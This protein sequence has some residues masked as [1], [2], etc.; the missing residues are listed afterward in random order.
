MEHRRSPDVQYF[1]ISYS[2]GMQGLDVSTEGQIL[3][4]SCQQTSSE[5]IMAG[6]VL[7]RDKH[8]LPLQGCIHA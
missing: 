3:P 4:P 2:H 7:Q 6:M 8:G 1:S 5:F